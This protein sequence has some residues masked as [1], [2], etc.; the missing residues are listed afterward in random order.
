VAYFS[1]RL[2]V[3]PHSIVILI[4]PCLLPLPLC[5]DTVS[6]YKQNDSLITL[7]ESKRRSNPQLTYLDQKITGMLSMISWLDNH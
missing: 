1:K 3:P 7:S 2:S 6:S 4:M 5:A